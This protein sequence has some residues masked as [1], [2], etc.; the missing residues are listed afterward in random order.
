MT[1]DE[2]LLWRFANANDQTAFA[3][4]VGNNLGLVYS[5]ALRRVGGDAHLAQDVCQE[6]FVLLARRAQERKLPAVC[7]RRDE[8]RDGLAV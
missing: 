7:Q 6:V 1:E 5:A 4:L 2:K 8:S 3:G